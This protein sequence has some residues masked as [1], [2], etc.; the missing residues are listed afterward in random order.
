MSR[1]RTVMLAAAGGVLSG[2]ALTAVMASNWRPEPE[3]VT[4]DPAEE[5]FVAAWERSRLGTFYVA[6]EFHRT[7]PNGELESV[8]E[9]AQRPP[10]VVRREFGG[11]EGRIGNRS[12]SCTLDPDDRE[13]CTQGGADLPPYD[14]EV[15]EEVARWDNYFVG[16]VPLYRVEMHEDGCFDLSLTRLSPSPPYGN[17]A[18]FCFD[19]ATGAMVYAEVHRDEGTDLLEAIEVR[20][21]VSDADLAIST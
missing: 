16:S 19:D 17:W 9:V 4:G 20:S 11:I 18:R 14:E 8:H 1:R 7:T 6:S 12:I 5:A 2:L 15:A 3:P 10:D 21:S 13:R